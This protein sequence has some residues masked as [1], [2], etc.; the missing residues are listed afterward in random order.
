LEKSAGVVCP[1]PLPLS[2]SLGRGEF[3]PPPCHYWLVARHFLSQQEIA[4]SFP[5]LTSPVDV[6]GTVTPSP[7]AG[8]AGVGV[9]R[10]KNVVQ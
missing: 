2:R 5:L 7:P 8:R 6:G 3:E 1:H 10:R 4:V 9:K